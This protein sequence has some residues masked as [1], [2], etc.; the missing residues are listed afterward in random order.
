[1]IRKQVSRRSFAVASMVSGANLSSAFAC[2]PC[3]EEARPGEWCRLL[4]DYPVAQVQ[5]ISPDGRWLC[6][7]RGSSVSRFRANLGEAFRRVGGASHRLVLVETG[8]WREALVVPLPSRLVNASFFAEGQRLLGEVHLLGTRDVRYLLID[9]PSMKS[10]VTTV[11]VPQGAFYLSWAC[12]ADR[13]LRL[14]R[15]EPTLPPP[16]REETYRL[17][18]LTSGVSMEEVGRLPEGYVH[19]EK[20]IGG[21]DIS[22]DRRWLLHSLGGEKVVF[23]SCIDLQERWALSVERGLRFWATGVSP[24]GAFAVCSVT[25]PAGRYGRTGPTSPRDHLLVIDAKKGVVLQRL[26]VA[27]NAC[28]NVAISGDGCLIAAGYI[29]SHMDNQKGVDETLID[30]IHAKTGQ[31]LQTLVHCLTKPNDRLESGLGGGVHFTAD[32]KYLISSGNSSRIWQL[33]EQL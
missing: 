21:P 2:A 28:E 6:L 24:N 3:E 17:F 1:M 4:R 26:A 18:R 22:L 11:S 31:V 13:V 30:L 12:A 5:A 9:A 7:N 15:R 16:Q 19:P 23:R 25:L 10:E 33:A 8:S 29:R 14:E 20:W 27:T 32:G